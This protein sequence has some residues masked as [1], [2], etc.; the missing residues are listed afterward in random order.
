MVWMR[1]S[2]RLRCSDYR[3]FLDPRGETTI[4]ITAVRQ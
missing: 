3:V 1:K 2:D 4:E